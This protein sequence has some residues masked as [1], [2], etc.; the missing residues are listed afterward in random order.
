MNM[1]RLILTIIVVFFVANLTGFLIHA[2]LLRADYMLIAQHYRPEGQEKMV[3]ISLAYLAFAIGSV[4]VYAKGVEDKPWLEQGIRFGILM[5]LILAI[6][7]FFIAY[8]V[9]PVPSALMVKQV[10]FETVDKVVLGIV[11]AAIYRR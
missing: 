6:P 2:Y 1:K 7:S 5:A 10:M 11:T 9:Q 8:A 3:F 4:I